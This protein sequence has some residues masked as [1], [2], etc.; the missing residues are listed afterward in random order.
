MIKNPKE[1]FVI[2]MPMAVGVGIFGALGIYIEVAIV[3]GVEAANE[4]LLTLRVYY[5]EGMLSRNGYKPVGNYIG[6]I[7][8]LL[9][10]W[11]VARFFLAPR[12]LGDQ[13]VKNGK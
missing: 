2:Y 7:F 13:Y 12:F 11:W 3:Q 8:G 4:W 9:W 6:I 10:G 1:A 5:P